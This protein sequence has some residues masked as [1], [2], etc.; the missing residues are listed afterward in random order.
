MGG[1]DPEGRLAGATAF[2]TSLKFSPTCL[3]TVQAPGAVALTAKHTVGLHTPLGNKK[4]LTVHTTMNARLKLHLKLL[5]R[6]QRN[7]R[8]A[9]FQDLLFLRRQPHSPWMSIFFF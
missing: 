7:A 6:D 1:H 3:D 8:F 2:S 9:C 5:L 4:A